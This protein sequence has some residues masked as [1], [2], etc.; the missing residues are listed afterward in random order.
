MIERIC[1]NVYHLALS[2][3]AK[4][5]Q[6]LHR[7]C[8]NFKYS[9]KSIHQKKGLQRNQYEQNK[10]ILCQHRDYEELSASQKVADDFKRGRVCFGPHCF[11]DCQVMRD[12]ALSD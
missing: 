3:K 12:V 11:M 5:S 10:S 9:R 4:C 1:A 2:A 6:E 8:S 7:I